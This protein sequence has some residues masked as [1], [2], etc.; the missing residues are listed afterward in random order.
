MIFGFD[1]SNEVMRLGRQSLDGAME[2]TVVGSFT[3]FGYSMRSRLYTWHELPDLTGRTIIITGPTS[4]LGYAAAVELSQFGAD[5]ILVGR[6]RDR[7][8]ATTQ[9][10]NQLTGGNVDYVIADMS[11][12]ASVRAASAE[13]SELPRIDALL[14]NAGALLNSYQ[15]TS[16]GYEKTFATHVLG[17]HVMTRTLLPIL[18][19]TGDARVITM[20]SG[21]MYAEKLDPAHVMMSRSE[22]DGVRAYAKAKRAQVALNEQWALR[23][24]SAAV[25]H[26]VHPGW[27][28]TPGI[29]GSLPRFNRAMG[30]F[31]R[32]PY[33][34]ADTMVWLAAS[35]E[36]LLSSG[37]LWLDRRP[38]HANKVPWTFTGIAQS[39]ELWNL[40]EEMTGA[41]SA[42]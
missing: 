12:L 15:K 31:L 14:H 6:D 38:R 42:S 25:F 24:P 22:Y 34:G 5:L 17:P 21:G 36:A 7:T 9:E 23:E 28:A 18:Q 3:R 35:D 29:A 8:S 13:L 30:P 19:R 33:Q 40:A 37:N 2:A 26:T 10:L 20:T 39:T 11:D 1:W 41:V 16:D 32:D 27:A 4:G